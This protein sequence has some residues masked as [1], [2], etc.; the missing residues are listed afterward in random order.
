M[1][2]TEFLSFLR[3][4]LHLSV[5]TTRQ[6]GILALLA[7]AEKPIDFGIAARNLQISKPSMSRNMD[8]L[9]HQGFASRIYNKYARGPDRRRIS[10][11]ITG[12]G[13]EFLAAMGVS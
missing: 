6:L 3:P 2:P 7:E 5:C 10:V 13:Q 12:D 11:G 4:T 1:T 8:S 9:E